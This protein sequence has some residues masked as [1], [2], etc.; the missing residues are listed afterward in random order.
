MKRNLRKKYT[1]ITLVRPMLKRNLRKK[2]YNGQSQFIFSR[3]RCTAA[4]QLFSFRISHFE[5]RTFLFT[6]HS[7][8]F[9]ENLYTYNL[10]NNVPFALLT[11]VSHFWRYFDRKQTT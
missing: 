11:K 6:N 9:E 5:L 7:F 1:V 3:Q 10:K 8:L 4:P 2:K